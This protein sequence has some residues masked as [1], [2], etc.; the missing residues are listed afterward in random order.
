M[1]Y[2]SKQEPI[3]S[4]L[5]ARRNEINAALGSMFAAALEQLGVAVVL[6]LEGD[7]EAG[8]TESPPEN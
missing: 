8:S 5:E 2:G 1:E 4:S 7:R 6:G 3:A